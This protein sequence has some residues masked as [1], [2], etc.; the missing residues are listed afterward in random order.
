MEYSSV[1][2]VGDIIQL[3]IAVLALFIAY[4]EYQRDRK[5]RIRQKSEQKIMNDFSEKTEIILEFTKLIHR[6]NTVCDSLNCINT[7]EEIND[8][9]DQNKEVFS[10]LELMRDQPAAKLKM[11]ILQYEATLTIDK[12]MEVRR[13][14]ED[15]YR[16]LLHNEHAFSFSCGFER[17]I[18]ACRNLYCGTCEVDY[19]NSF[20][21]RKKVY[22]EYSLPDLTNEAEFYYKKLTDY[23]N[24][25]DKLGQN[26]LREAGEVL[27]CFSK[28]IIVID[29]RLIQFIPFLTELKIKYGDVKK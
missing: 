14:V 11:D 28:L 29:I 27:G 25:Y 1:L 6:F 3:I 10:E 23:C 19:D 13:I 24:S 5:E 22:T 26:Q 16:E 8:Y 20:S 18:N 2:S 4:A 17:T 12:T 15:L 7:V 21:I 9:Y